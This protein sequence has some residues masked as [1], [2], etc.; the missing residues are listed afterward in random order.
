MSDPELLTSLERLIQE[1]QLSQNRQ[2]RYAAAILCALRAAI[3]SGTALQ[4]LNTVT[5]QHTKPML[6]AIERAKRG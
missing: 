2:I 6:E 4:L 5:E 3:A 1:M